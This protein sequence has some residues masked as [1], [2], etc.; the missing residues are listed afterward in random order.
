M[1]PTKVPPIKAPTDQ[2]FALGIDAPT[3]S[4]VVSSVEVPTPTK[5]MKGMKGMKGTNGM[6]GTKGTKGMKA[7]KGVNGMNGMNGTKLK[8]GGKKS[9]VTA[10]QQVSTG[11]EIT[12]GTRHRPFIQFLQETFH[13]KCRR[14]KVACF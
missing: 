4:P 6:K 3:L 9:V 1:I 14:W 2:P 10:T 11:T 13:L 7:M 8:N 5:G 12:G